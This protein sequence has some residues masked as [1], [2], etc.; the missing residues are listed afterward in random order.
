[1]EI[2]TAIPWLIT[3]LDDHHPYIRS[4]VSV[5]TKLVGHGEYVIACYPDI[6]NAGMKLSF[7]RKLGRPFHCSLSC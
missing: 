1:M 7:A 3:L 4:T 2:R 5:L 6:A